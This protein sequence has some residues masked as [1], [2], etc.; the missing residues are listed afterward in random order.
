[1]KYFLPLLLAL[2]GCQTTKQPQV[3]TE[4]LQAQE[5]YK[6][7]LLPAGIVCLEK[8]EHISCLQVAEPKQPGA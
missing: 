8:G 4:C 2:A 3:P 1:M 6:L 5:D 7:C